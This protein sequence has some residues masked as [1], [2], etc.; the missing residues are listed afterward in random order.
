MVAGGAQAGPQAVPMTNPT[1]APTS[2]GPC[3]LCFRRGWGQQYAKVPWGQVSRSSRSPNPAPPSSISPHHVDHQ[4]DSQGKRGDGLECSRM[5]EGTAGP[6]E[7]RRGASCGRSGHQ[8]GPPVAAAG[9][10]GAC[11]VWQHD[12]PPLVPPGTSQQPRR[13]AAGSREPHRPAPRGWGD[14]AA[15]PHIPAAPDTPTAEMPTALCRLWPTACST[16]S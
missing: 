3:G 16:P 10:L 14:D 7:G 1:H 11:L 2:M 9:A 13:V 15:T 6:Q 5:L 12:C 4:Q 8:A